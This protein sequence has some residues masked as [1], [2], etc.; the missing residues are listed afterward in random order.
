MTKEDIVKRLIINDALFRNI[1]I[2]EQ[3]FDI[4]PKNKPHVGAAIA[5]QDLQELRIDFLDELVNTVADW[6]YSSE[7]FSKMK[8]Q[9]MRAGRSEASAA[10]AV[11]SKAKSKFRT[12]DNRLSIQGQLGELLLFHFIQRIKQAV[13]L[14]RKMPIMT[15]SH[16]ERFGADAIHYKI[17]NNKNILIIGEAKTY[18]SKYKFCDAFQDALTS[19][20]GSYANLRSELRQYVHEDFLNDELDL[21][22]EAVLENTLPN[23]EVELI[24]IVVYNETQKIS[25]TN[26]EDIKQQIEA[27]IQSRFASFENS[28][29]DLQKNPILKRITYIVFPI[30]KLDELAK[31]FQ[32]LL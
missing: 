12:D 14:L 17:E 4:E 11:L 8:Q 6:V 28:K 21:I 31:N 7:K 19:I 10:S 3:T 5:F 25:M 22:A 1:Y 18:T 24:S 27:I 20:L 2:F 23:L 9:Y 15:S 30:W 26:E 16:H 29:I 32:S 13:P